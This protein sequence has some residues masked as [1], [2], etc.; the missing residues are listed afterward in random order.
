MIQHVANREIPDHLRR[1]SAA[2]GLPPV[3][4]VFSA[5]ADHCPIDEN[6]LEKH[7]CDWVA[8]NDNLPIKPGF[9]GVHPTDRGNEALAQVVQAAIDRDLRA[10]Y[11]VGTGATNW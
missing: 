7:Q 6:T 1:I 10:L 2:R 11:V 5:F 3:V 4:D 9:E 8:T